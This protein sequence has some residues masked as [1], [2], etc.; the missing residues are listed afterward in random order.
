MAQLGQ[1]SLHV[2][3]ADDHAVAL[4]RNR[5][6]ALHQAPHA[7]ACG[8]VIHE[9]LVAVIDGDMLHQVHYS[10]G[11]FARRN[12]LFHRSVHRALGIA[13]AARHR[14]AQCH[15][16]GNHQPLLD[17]FHRHLIVIKNDNR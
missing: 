11:R 10:L 17:L 4:A 8:L 7:D 13:L 16:G 12:S 15:H 6:G 2:T 5:V 9:R 14:A 3:L 1:G